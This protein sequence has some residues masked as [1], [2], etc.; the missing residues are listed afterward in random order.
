MVRVDPV[1]SHLRTVTP[2]LVV[3][4]AS[5]AIDFYRRAFAAEELGDRFAGPHGEVVHAELRIGDAVVMLTDEAIDPDPPAKAPPSLGGMVSAIM[6]TPTGR[7]WTPPGSEQCPPAPRSSTR[8]PISSTE[9]TPGGFATL[10]PSVDDEPADRARASGRDGAS[11][12]H[13]L[14]VA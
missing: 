12:R 9:T 14:R 5:S 3:R 8:W 4:D 6:A 13:V 11:H 7:T 2:R 10:R 1:L